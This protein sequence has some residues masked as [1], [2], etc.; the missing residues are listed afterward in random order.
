MTLT[1]TKKGFLG[2]EGLKVLM[3]VQTEG[4]ANVIGSVHTSQASWFLIIF[5]PL[6]K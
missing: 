2:G 3:C 1:H 6:L 4:E 5:S